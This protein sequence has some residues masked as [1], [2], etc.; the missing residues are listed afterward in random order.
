MT[1][2][3]RF[4]NFFKLVAKCGTIKGEINK[5]G[6]RLIAK[7]HCYNQV[8]SQLNKTFGAKLIYKKMCW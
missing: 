6:L 1:P 4:G 2:N 5:P 8:N 7:K 3:R